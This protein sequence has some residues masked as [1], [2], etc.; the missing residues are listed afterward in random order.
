MKSYKGLT[1]CSQRFI[2]KTKSFNWTDSCLYWRGYFRATSA[3]NRPE[4]GSY[5][6]SM[7]NTLSVVQCERESRCARTIHALSVRLQY[8]NNDWMWSCRWQITLYP[9]KPQRRFFSEIIVFMFI[10]SVGNMLHPTS[11]MRYKSNAWE[12]VR[13]PKLE[14]PQEV[15]Y[16]FCPFWYCVFWE[17]MLNRRHAAEPCLSHA[18]NSGATHNNLI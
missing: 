10:P 1:S 13:S 5:C 8:A 17:N 18:R 12:H 3:D 9:Q 14:E 11:M 15:K 2:H 7:R 6:A 4:R 16:L